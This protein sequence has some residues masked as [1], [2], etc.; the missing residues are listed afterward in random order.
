MAVRQ[1]RKIDYDGLI[2]EATKALD[3]C[4]PPDAKLR[5]AAAVLTDKGNI[6]CGSNY[7][8]DTASLLLHGEQTALAHAANHKDPNIVAIA[9]V[10]QGEAILPVSTVAVKEGKG[11]A[12]PCGICRQLIWEN[13]QRSGHNVKVIMA[14]L[15]G[16]YIVKDIESLVPHPWPEKRKK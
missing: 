12:Y 14:N 4:Y 7:G 3:T 15:Q 16:K 5:Y 11:F 6:Y 2:K 9:I 8:S 13:A 10:G 1:T